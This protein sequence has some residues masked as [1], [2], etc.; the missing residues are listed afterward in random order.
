MGCRSSALSALA[1]LTFLFLFSAMSGCGS[2]SSASDSATAPTSSTAPTEPTPAPVPAPVPAPPAK[3]APPPV[4][5]TKPAPPPVAPPVTSSTS[6]DACIPATMPST[7]A[8]FNS[9]KRVFA[10]YF[11][12]FPV[13]IDNAAPANDYYNKEYLSPTGESSKFAKQGGFLR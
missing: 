2:S 10:H 13:S 12:P 11:H 9:S 6:G 3:P 8:L 7:D 5:P 4:A 1:P